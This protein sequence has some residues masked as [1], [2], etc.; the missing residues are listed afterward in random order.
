MGNRSLIIIR[1][2]EFPAKTEIRLYGHWAGEDNFH[3][4]EKVLSRT[5]RIG[6]PAYLIAQLF[7]E[8][9]TERGAYSGELGYGI[10]VAEIGSD[11]GWIDSPTVYLNADFGYYDYEGE[12]YKPKGGTS[13]SIPTVDKNRAEPEIVYEE[14][15]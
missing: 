8:F 5:N 12:T 13:I 4:V 7:H 14:R 9:A 10:S 11:E 1:S 2:S 6:D 3:A 15:F